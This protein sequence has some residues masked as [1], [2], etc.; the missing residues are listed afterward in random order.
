MPLQFLNGG[1]ISAMADELGNHLNGWYP[2]LPKESTAVCR[3]VPAAARA[4]APMRVQAHSPASAQR[5]VPV[6]AQVGL[7]FKK[8]TKLMQD[9]VILKLRG[10]PF[11]MAWPLMKA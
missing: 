2:E 4:P 10:P 11:S 3:R 6:K 9:L 7:T 8:V 1:R 5:R